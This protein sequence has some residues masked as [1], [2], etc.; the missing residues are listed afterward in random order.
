MNP[1]SPVQIV[2]CPR[3]AM[4]GLHD[5]IPTETK[6]AYL[7]RLLR[8]G[9]HT[10]DFGSFVSPKAVPQMAD[11]AEALARL[12]RSGSPTLLLAIVANERGA[13]DA[14]AH[15]EIDLLGYPL[16]ISETFQQRNTKRSVAD[17]VA[18]ARDLQAA[19][20]GAG[21]RLV[22]YLSMGFGNP[23]GDPW[24]AELLAEHA[25]GM[26]EIGV[27]VISLA[28]TVGTADPAVVEAAFAHLTQEL[29]HITFGAHLHASPAA[30]RDK[31]EAAWRG[32]CRRFDGAL[33]G[34]G[35]CPFAKDELVGNIATENLVLFLTERNALP[36]SLNREAFGEALAAAGEVFG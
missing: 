32:G 33:R 11:T 12:D 27:E 2:E 18:L 19:C 28:D 34:F 13:A 10:L 5:F 29:P 26:A 31:V 9:F 14:L 35:G 22:V 15:P 4:Q 8:A 24:S 6:A 25:H 17:S 36:E 23:Y 30:W 3:D 16:S 7:N 20:Q 21:R 1:V